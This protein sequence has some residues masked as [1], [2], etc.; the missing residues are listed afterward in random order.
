MVTCAL[1]RKIRQHIGENGL[2]TAEPDIAKL[3]INLKKQTEINLFALCCLQ[4]FSLAWWKREHGVPPQALNQ[5]Y[6]TLPIQTFVLGISWEKAPNHQIKHLENKEFCFGGFFFFVCLF[7]WMSSSA[8]IL[9]ETWGWMNWEGS[10]WDNCGSEVCKACDTSVTAACCKRPKKLRDGVVWCAITSIA[11]QVLLSLQHC[12]TPEGS[13]NY[14]KS[15][16]LFIF[17]RV[18]FSDMKA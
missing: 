9:W 5:R 15:R 2:A 14:F 13:L 10:P 16:L 4:W 18:S 11:T 6:T 17:M 12:I 7:F 1:W 3:C 8:Y